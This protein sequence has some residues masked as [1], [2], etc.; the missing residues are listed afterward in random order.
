MKRAVVSVDGLRRG[1][2]T[3]NVPADD[4]INRRVEVN[5]RRAQAG[6]GCETDSTRPSGPH[7][8]IPT[9]ARDWVSSRVVSMSSLDGSSWI[10]VTTSVAGFRW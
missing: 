3:T 2:L 1:A 8:T 5:R 6:L 7:S 4:E 9:I 10:P